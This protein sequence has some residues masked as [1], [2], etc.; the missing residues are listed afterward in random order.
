ML[1][2]LSRGWRRREVERPGAVRG[3]ADGAMRVPPALAQAIHTAHCEARLAMAEEEAVTRQATV[4]AQV[5]IDER[6]VQLATKR[7]VA[8]EAAAEQ[9]AIVAALLGLVCALA[10]VATDIVLVAPSLDGFNL[11]DPLLQ[12]FGAMGIVITPMW[13]LDRGAADVESTSRGR[14]V[15]G[16]MSLVAAVAYCVG[17]GYWRATQ[18]LAEAEAI[19]DLAFLVE[20]PILTSTVLV[21]LNTGLPLMV[22]RVYDWAMP[23]LTAALATAAARRRLRRGQKRL[24]R[25]QAQAK[26]VRPGYETRALRLRAHSEAV[27]ARYQR[28]Y[29]LGVALTG[30]ARLTH[31]LAVLCCGLGLGA[32]LLYRVWL[33]L[34]FAR[35][36]S[37]VLALLTVAGLSFLVAVA[38]GRR[39]EEA[40]RTAP[41]RLAATSAQAH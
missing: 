26:S 27:R 10:A 36:V 15:W 24:A 25:S 11:P 14:R 5:A 8:F 39:T 34:G 20:R 13:L 23:S 16:V 17:F 38:T 12:Y 35:P 4:D 37:A 29:E 2:F 1:T 28:G 9:R 30:G 32:P 22:A 19:D 6:A 31:L 7:V 33:S 41:S 21:L 40:P 18:L 3:V